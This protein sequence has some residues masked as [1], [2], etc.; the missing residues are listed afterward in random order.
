MVHP[1]PDRSIA[2]DVVPSPRLRVVPEPRTAPLIAPAALPAGS[3]CGCG[4]SKQAHTHYRRGT[5]CAA[6]ACARF[7]RPLLARLRRWGR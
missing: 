4:H 3:P 1:L 7:D 6:C 2:P 5:D